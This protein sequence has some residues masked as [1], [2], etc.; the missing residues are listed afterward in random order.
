MSR[1]LSTVLALVC[2][3]LAAGPAAAQTS[4]GPDEQA[5]ET[6]IPDDALPEEAGPEQAG[7]PG[8]SSASVAVSG[9]GRFLEAPLALRARL[10]AMLRDPAPGRP[11][12][13]AQLGDSHTEWGLFTGPFAAA[14]AGGGTVAPGFVA[15]WERGV[16][17]AKIAFS[18][19]WRRSHW[20]THV[21][22]GVDGPSGTSALASA[23]GARAVL[24]LPPAMPEGT[25]VTAWWDAESSGHFRVTVGGVAL[26]ALDEP[27]PMGGALSQRSWTLPADTRAL[28]LVVDE[29][30]VAR[31]F[32]FCG[33][34]VDRPDAR[35]QFD[36]LGLGGSVHLHP[37]RQQRGALEAF[38][39]SR[40]HDLVVIWY[41]TNSAP[42][43]G[44][45]PEAFGRQYEELLQL[46]RRA[47]PGAAV[48]ALGLPDLGWRG[49]GCRA[50]AV[51][52]PK[53]AVRRRG[54]RGPAARHPG[55]GVHAVHARPATA[56]EK[57]LERLR[58]PKRP[59]LAAKRRTR[60]GKR[61]PPLVCNPEPGQPPLSPLATDSCYPATPPSVA[62]LRDRE[63]AAA[64]A[65]GA[66][67]FDLYAYMGE[68]GGMVRW[69]CQSPALALPD[70]VHLSAAGYRHV[71]AVLAEA[72]RTAAPPV[73]GAD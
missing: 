51:I 15:P 71:A 6:S 34:T 5:D 57:R 14:I 22:G 35:V 50:G 31:P 39:A 24:K 69:Y 32:R 66:A 25:R 2:L 54:A 55:E 62:A 73:A 44:L 63:R 12:R 17:A 45:S 26:R 42:E 28:E 38:L 64:A 59:S 48:V 68:A 56:A 67:F 41:G 49:K 3:A 13:V 19:G 29:A 47:S 8:A 61:Y 18:S 16:H 21:K 43:K 27:V 46:V 20:R 7:E 72:L 60:R 10:A 65:Q 11:W 1:V 52:P 40:E 30:S 70:F 9:P 23:R 4:A 53:K 33:F 37:L 58:E 36:G